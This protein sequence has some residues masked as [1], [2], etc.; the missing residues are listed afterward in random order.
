MD[1]PKYILKSALEGKTS[2][3]E[4]PAY[5]PEDENKF[6]VSLLQNYFN[7]VSEKIEVNDINE[8][9]NE[10]N[11][12]LTKCKKIEN[13]NKE[14]L[15][16][17][18]MESITELFDIPEDT[19]IISSDLVNK[20][21]PSDERLIPEATTD[22]NFDSIEDINNLTKEIYKRRMLL[23]LVSGASMYY[24]EDI[25]RY[26]KE[27][28]EI[29]SEL[30][31]LYKKIM[32]IN[33][34]LLFMEKDTMDTSKSTSAGKVDVFISSSDEQVRIKSEALFFPILIEETIKGLLELSISHGLPSN[35]EKA[36]Y[37]VMKSD[38]KLAE[39]WDMRLG[40]PLWKRLAEAI[41]DCGYDPIEI[42]LNFIFMQISTLSPDKFNSVLQ[43]IFAKT[44]RGKIFTKNIIEKIIYEK[45]HDEFDDYINQKSSDDEIQ[46]NDEYYTPE[47]LITDCEIY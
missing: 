12:S 42:G 15:E 16:K 2:L 28:F 8:L 27:L 34:Y 40:L 17:L 47:E 21:D 26:I 19:I 31:S 20:I 4:H 10:L 7:E 22:F 11:V 30:P 5:P 46:I 32:N 37:V 9:K 23:A 35:R 24:S 1:L 13:K 14:S 33:T 38:F 6:I 45:E 18:C 36:K 41:L 25:T 39:L 43:E 44:K 29:D 3:G